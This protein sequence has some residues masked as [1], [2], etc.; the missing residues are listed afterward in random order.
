MFCPSPRLSNSADQR[1]LIK[2]SNYYTYVT[3]LV[4]RPVTL[5]CICFIRVLQPH[6][7]VHACAVTFLRSQYITDV[8]AV[9]IVIVRVLNNVIL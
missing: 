2:Y 8:A 1:Y 6:A 3:G 4:P 5:P 7:H 9:D